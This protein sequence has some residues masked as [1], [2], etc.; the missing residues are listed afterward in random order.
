MS[1]IFENGG[2]VNREK[3]QEANGEYTY[4]TNHPR[5]KYHHESTSNDLEDYGSVETDCK[6]LAEFA[7][8]LPVGVY[9]LR[10][11]TP[12]LI[13]IFGCEPSPVYVT[14]EMVMDTRTN[15][16][17]V[18]PNWRKYKDTPIISIH[19]RDGW[20]GTTFYVQLAF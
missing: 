14:Q 9:T 20:G 3:P 7:N 11:K 8:A 1:E 17:E 13:T 4:D 6:T 12:Q 2:F 19:Y 5:I 15:H 16:H 10:L 18:K